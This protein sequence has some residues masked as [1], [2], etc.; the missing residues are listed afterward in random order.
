[1]MTTRAAPSGSPRRTIY[2]KLS[3]LD[4]DIDGVAGAAG[5][6][7][8]E[9][10]EVEAVDGPFGRE[11]EGQELVGALDGRGEEARLQRG[12]VGEEVEG[13][14]GGGIEGEAHQAVIDL[15]VLD[16]YRIDR[17]ET[18]HDIR[19]VDESVGC[20]AV[21]VNATE[22]SIG[23]AVHLQCVLLEAYVEGFG[24]VRR[25]FRDVAKGT[26]VR[27]LLLAIGVAYLLGFAAHNLFF[28]DPVDGV[29]K[30]S[31]RAVEFVAL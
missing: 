7:A 2:T 26:A 4:G 25:E 8:E 15:D 23:L 10:V 5:A 30:V 21:L 28:G 27:P 16:D 24:H 29:Y 11:L 18:Q 22:V 12:A 6:V 31:F 14:C 1:M 20:E 19:I 3:L 17:T 13:I 9:G